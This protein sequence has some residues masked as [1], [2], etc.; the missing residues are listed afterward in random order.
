MPYNERAPHKPPVRGETP[1]RFLNFHGPV[2]V[3]MRDGK[4]LPEPE[5][6]PVE[7]NTEPVKLESVERRARR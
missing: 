6:I 2:K 4:S 5:L 1:D 7:A 3:L